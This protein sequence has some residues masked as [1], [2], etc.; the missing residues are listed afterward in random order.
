M[1]GILIS[2]AMNI[3]MGVLADRINR[4]MMV[5]AGGL[6]VGYAILSFGWADSFSEMVIASAIFGIGGGICMPAL[7]AM[8]AWRGSQSGAMGRVMAYMT[9]AHSLGML[10]GAL[11]GG[12]MMDLFRLQLAFPVSA[13]VM[14]LS[15][16]FFLAGTYRFKTRLRP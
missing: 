12:F 1:M 5:T 4:R 3:P 10:S 15:I 11:L 6:I 9:M 14:T 2:G 16:G 8:A 13:L 7:M